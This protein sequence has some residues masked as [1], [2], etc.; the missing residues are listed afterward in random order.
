MQRVA[1]RPVS[2]IVSFVKRKYIPRKDFPHTHVSLANELFS[3]Q[4]VRQHGRL[5]KSTL[6][7]TIRSTLTGTGTVGRETTGTG[8]VGRETTD[9]GTGRCASTLLRATTGTLGRTATAFF[10]GWVSINNIVC[11]VPLVSTVLGAPVVLRSLLTV[12]LTLLAPQFLQT[13][14]VAAFNRPH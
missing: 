12:A 11:L 3:A 13:M 8:T 14:L 2:F 7:V 9:T 10:V 6:F 1:L 4:Q 5:K